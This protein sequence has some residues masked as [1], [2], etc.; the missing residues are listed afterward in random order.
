ML[1]HASYKH[2]LENFHFTASLCSEVDHYYS[3]YISY[4]CLLCL[5]R[6]QTKFTSGAMFILMYVSFDYCLHF[7]FTLSRPILFYSHDIQ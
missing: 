3:W 5:E 4:P 1:V 2:F 6:Q 7:P